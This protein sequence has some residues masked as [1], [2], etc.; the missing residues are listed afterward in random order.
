MKS[1]E[2][3]G[4]NFKLLLDLQVLKVGSSQLASLR[5]IQ[6]RVVASGSRKI[7][8]TDIQI[9]IVLS[10]AMAE[11]ATR[12]TSLLSSLFK[13]SLLGTLKIKKAIAKR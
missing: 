2:N 6:E 5:D 7:C 10:P 12:S 11:Q 9:E 13:Y 4:W 1:C 8:I 3:Q